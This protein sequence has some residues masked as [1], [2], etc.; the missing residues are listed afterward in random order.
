[1]QMSDSE[2]NRSINLDVLFE[3]DTGK[4]IGQCRAIP[5]SLGE[6]GN[7]ILVVSCADFDI[8]PFEEMFF[9]PKDT[10][11]CVLLDEKGNALW[12]RDLGPG[13]VPGV[14]FCPFFS[15]DLDQDGIDEIWFVNNLQPDH[16]LALRHYALER[17][18]PRTGRTTGQWTWPHEDCDQ[19]P[20]HL[21]RNFILGGFVEGKPVLVT[22]QG[23]YGNMFL[24]GWN[25]EMTARWSIRIGKDEPG[26]R[27]SHMCPVVDINQDG[28]D[29]LL[30]GERCISLD[31][32][33]ELFCADRD[34]YNGHSDIIQ[35][36]LDRHTDAWYFLACREGDDDAAPRVAVYDHAGVRV[37]GD[38]EK[39]HM[40][41][42]WVA[43]WGEESG[44]VAAA[45]RIGQ[46][47]CGPDGRHHQGLDE[48]AYDALTGT[49]RCLPFSAYRMIPVDV[50]GDGVHEFVRGAP[51]G[52]GEVLD[53]FGTRVGHVGGSVALACRFLDHPGEQILSYTEKGI[54]QVWVDRHAEDSPLATA[55]YQHPYYTTNRHIM[56]NGYNWWVLS[57]I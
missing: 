1:M 39:G 51:G 49:P 3:Y 47:T 15:F 42:G 5:V 44:P 29:E 26:A 38:V 13:V 53:R 50:N 22:A 8:D 12:T 21:F 7:G 24:Q 41:L 37:W 2:M 4:E 27:G 31:T 36:F 45:I 14:W 10:L 46:K 40:D 33:T 25:P 16:P 18:D 30:W 56:A 54:I 9:F 19:T 17:M 57:G 23:T 11:T 34:T 6:R 55:R 35:P 28:T 20:S 48:Y 43:Q 52:D 32:G